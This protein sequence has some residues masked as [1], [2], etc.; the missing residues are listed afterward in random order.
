MS[1][2][3]EDFIPLS[4]SG[5]HA[6][7][8]PNSR[9]AALIED[10]FH[11]LVETPGGGVSVRGDAKSRSHAKET[12][13]SLAARADAGAEVTEA[14]VRATMA[15][16]RAGKPVAGATL[17]VGRKGPIAPKTAA[18]ARYLDMLD[19]CELVFGVGPAGTGK[20]F[21]AVAYGATLLLKGAVDRLVVTRPAVEAGERLGFLP[22]DMNEKVDPYMAPVWQALDDILGPEA[23]RRRRDRGEIEVAPLAFMRGR[24]LSH[25]F[26]IVDEAQNSTRLQVKMVLTRLGEGSRMVVT[27]DPSQVD[28]VNPRDS[29]LAHAVSLL[30]GVKGVDVGRF[31]ASD[32]VRH[33]MVERIVRAYDADAVKATE[34]RTKK[35]DDDD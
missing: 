3:A 8:G 14:D 1:P 27:G 4:D 7:S 29:G 33:P 30:E 5:V 19:R 18:Q 21:L 10:A 15:A 20:T 31:E 24:T 13:L 16:V 23:A 32:V 2:R 11:V 35:H 22:G 25:A 6:V 34:R 9:H 17:T 28:L 12:I 26:I